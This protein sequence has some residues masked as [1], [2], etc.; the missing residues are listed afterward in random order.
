[1][2]KK[3]T[4]AGT[5]LQNGEVSWRFGTNDLDARKRNLERAGFS[6]VR[7]VQLPRAMTR[8]EAIEYVQAEGLLDSLPEV[9]AAPAQVREQA[10]QVL[11][12]IAPST[13]RG[14]PRYD[15]WGM[16]LNAVDRECANEELARSL[17]KK[18]VT[19]FLRW[20]DQLTPACRNEF[21]DKADRQVTAEAAAKVAA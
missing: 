10:K 1:M 2:D 16:E 3:W 13:R 9:A 21:R 8:E 18:S 5:A 19:S 4:L 6:N 12:N 15:V 17:H 20:D 14:T 7:L 11:L